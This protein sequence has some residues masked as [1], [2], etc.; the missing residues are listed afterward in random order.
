[1][2][3]SLNQLIKKKFNVILNME[4]VEHVL[5]VDLF[6]QNYLFHFNNKM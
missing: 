6:I 4:I 3:N 5:D 1:M 2:S